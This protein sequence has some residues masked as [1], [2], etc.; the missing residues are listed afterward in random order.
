VMILG[1]HWNSCIRQLLAHGFA[2]SAT[3]FGSWATSHDI[4]PIDQGRHP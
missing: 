1:G 4:V 2:G 3:R